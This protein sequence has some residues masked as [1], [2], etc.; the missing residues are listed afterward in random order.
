VFIA[1]DITDNRIYEKAELIVTK[2]GKI[3]QVVELL[4]DL[5][6]RVLCHWYW[7]DFD[8]IFKEVSEI[9]GK[10]NSHCHNVF[11]ILDED[12]YQMSSATAHHRAMGG[13]P[14]L[15]KLREKHSL[16][17]L[18]EVVERTSGCISR[19]EYLMG[20][21]SKGPILRIAFLKLPEAERMKIVEGENRLP[22]EGAVDGKK[23]EPPRSIADA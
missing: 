15:K 1:E 9:L 4:R 10:R 19:L 8:L 6:P 21:P 12:A 5:A 17:E 11:H 22:S 14:Q 16:R 18:Q 13:G 3:A 7:K 20:T 2:F 23:K